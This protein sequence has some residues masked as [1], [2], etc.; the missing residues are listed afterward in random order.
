MRKRA[1]TGKSTAKNVTKRSKSP[2]RDRKG[3]AQA[4]P[5]HA[6]TI[7]VEKL[8]NCEGEAATEVAESTEPIAPMQTEPRPKPQRRG[9][10][11]KVKAAT[12][13]GIL[14]NEQEEGSTARS[15]KRGRRQKTK[16]ALVPALESKEI[17]QEQVEPDKT[18]PQRRRRRDAQQDAHPSVVDPSKTQERSPCAEAAGESNA[19]EA[20][21]TTDAFQ[22]TGPHIADDGAKPTA[23]TEPTEQCRPVKPTK[24][25]RRGRPPKE[26]PASFAK[27]RSTQKTAEEAHEN[28]PVQP[29]RRT[30]RVAA[31]QTADIKSAK[32]NK[33][34][35]QEN[36]KTNITIHEDP[37]PSPP[38]AQKTTTSS[39]KQ[40]RQAAA[41]PTKK[42]PLPRQRR[43]LQ[44]P[45]DEDPS[46]P[47][48]PT[49]QTPQD[50]PTPPPENAHTTLQTTTS[51]PPTQKLPPASPQPTPY[52]PSPTPPDNETAH[53]TTTMPPVKTKRTAQPLNPAPSPAQ[54]IETR[55]LHRPKE[56]ARGALTERTNIQAASARL[57]RKPS[58][59]ERISDCD[60]SDSRDL[61]AIMRR[62]GGVRVPERLAGRGRADGRL[63]F[64]F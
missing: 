30:R 29:R 55:P 21:G 7:A 61:G 25:K 37:D 57:V 24:S 50:K 58:P 27:G 64:R 9:R 2:D 32:E 38:A 63:R 4:S 28:T 54:H 14:S 22:T 1:R 48:R 62:V 42:Q 23:E 6:K 40:R 12:E 26:I 17:V 59:R 19:V 34:K 33:G 36:A 44:N 52:P 43:P 18:R 8:P 20:S 47:S 31:P 45:P 39:P 35:R 13:G 15:Q 41:A 56:T 60:S 11:P 16:Q 5:V 10:P 46:P 51:S 53:A 49:P 3:G